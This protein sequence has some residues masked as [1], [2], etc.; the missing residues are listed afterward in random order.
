MSMSRSRD[1]SMGWRVWVEERRSGGRE[2][3]G[4]GEERTNLGI[5][6]LDQI[7]I[8][9]HDLISLILTQAEQLRQREPLAGHLI[10]V[11]GIDELIVVHTIGR[12]PPH[13]LNGWLAP[14]E[15]EDVIEQGLTS[16]RER[17]GFRRVGRH[18]LGRG[19]LA[20]LEVLPRG[21]GGRREVGL[22][23]RR[24]GVGL[25]LG[26]FGGHVAGGGGLSEGMEGFVD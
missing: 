5:L 11:I 16:G 21:R 2:E 10:P 25:R 1:V 23:L 8:I 9:D 12:V 14:V 6:K 17:D 7:T 26:G 13:A 19:R 4:K 20:G 24:R 15:G 22:V 3:E 18:V